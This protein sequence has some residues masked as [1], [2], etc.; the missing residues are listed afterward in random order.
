MIISGKNSVFE[1]LNSGKTINKVLIA[2]YIH[3]DFSKKVVELCKKN[4]VRFDFVDKKQLEKLAEHN[5]GFVAEVTEF[6]YSTLEEILENKKGDYN[7]IVILDNVQDP[8]NFGSIIRVCECAGVDGI[9]IES[10]RSCNVNET[11]YK[12]SCG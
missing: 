9:V 7:F 1:A 11:V 3:D 6:N 4:K 2:N 10:R 8:H 5:Q 12:T